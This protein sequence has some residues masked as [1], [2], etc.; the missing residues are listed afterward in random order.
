MPMKYFHVRVFSPEMDAVLLLFRLVVGSA[1]IYH[2]WPLIQ[3][4]MNW[5]GAGSPVP[6]VFQFLAAVSEFG[7]GIS[8]VLGLLTRLSS[9]GIGIT[10]AVAVCMHRFV[11]GDPFVSLTGGR[12]YELASVYFLVALLVL[13]AGPGRISLDQKVFGSRQ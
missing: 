3:H 2:G 4:P 8:W 5:M 10:M 9:L 1:F 13:I 6:A 7:G 12:S 11:L